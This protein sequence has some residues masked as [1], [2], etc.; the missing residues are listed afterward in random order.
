MRMTNIQRENMQHRENKEIMKEIEL[1][2]EGSAGIKI[3]KSMRESW[4]R[5]CAASTTGI[6]FVPDSWTS[7]YKRSTSNFLGGAT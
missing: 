1:F 2:I 7:H 4:L 5:Y 6:K 3:V